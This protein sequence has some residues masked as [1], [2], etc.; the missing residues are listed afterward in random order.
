LIRVPGTSTKIAEE[1]VTYYIVSQ[2]FACTDPYGNNRKVAYKTLDKLIQDLIGEE[3]V[4]KKIV[5]SGVSSRQLHGVAMSIL[6]PSGINHFMRIFTE[7][8]SKELFLEL[9]NMLMNIVRIQADVKKKKKKTTKKAV[10]QFKKYTKLYED[11]ID[12][13]RKKLGIRKS[14]KG[15][16]LKSLI[17][18]EKDG[19]KYGD[20]YSFS[21]YID[22]ED[23]DE[24]DSSDKGSLTDDWL[25]YLK[26]NGVRD[27]R[28][29]PPRRTKKPFG[30]DL[31]ED[32]DDE[33]EEDD[34]ITQGDAIRVLADVVNTLSQQINTL[35]R[36]VDVVYGEEDD[37][38]EDDDDEEDNSPTWASPDKDG[39]DPLSQEL[40]KALST[41]SQ[42]DVA[43][44]P[45][46]APAATSQPTGKE[47]VSASP[48][49]DIVTE[50]NESAAK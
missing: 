3:D 24:W 7:K 33:E 5:T 4:V 30:F 31:D 48:S 13:L 1:R 11:G 46:P 23:D 27:T 43:E 16:Y 40:A 21:R 32:D 17:R 49:V 6:R 26:D 12:I 18:E 28:R 14:G 34:D 47:P 20:Y 8:R 50:F 29:N 36:K 35:S 10:K 37:E 44:K 25:D 19:Y 45:Q 39:N 42:E 41:W 38:D 2:L 9:Y 22:N 15:G